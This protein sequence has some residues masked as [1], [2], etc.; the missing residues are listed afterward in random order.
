M[1]P[2][3]KENPIMLVKFE[4]LQTYSIPSTSPLNN[5]K[6]LFQYLTIKQ[7]ALA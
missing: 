7:F 5:A 3:E 4:V 2:S 1:Y 6:R